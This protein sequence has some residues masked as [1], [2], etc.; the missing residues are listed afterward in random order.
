MKAQEVITRLR[1]HQQ[2][3][4]EAGI[5]GLSLFG[6][7]ARGDHTATSDVDLVADF[8]HGLSILDLVSIENRLTDLLGTTVDLSDRTMLKQFVR[9]QTEREALHVF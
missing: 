3:L 9:S 6:S 2:E 8:V 7:V 5:R 1:E 4:S